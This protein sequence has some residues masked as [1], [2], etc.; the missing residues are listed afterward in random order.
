MNFWTRF[1]IDTLGGY[2]Q[3]KAKGNLDCL[4]G[5]DYDVGV[6]SEIIADGSS[7]STMRHESQRV[8]TLELELRIPYKMGALVCIEPAWEVLNQNDE[9]ESA[10]TNNKESIIK[11]KATV[12][13]PKSGIN[14]RFFVKNAP[15]FFFSTLFE[16]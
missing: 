1:D 8:Q 9:E 6:C 11:Q 3:C 16:K 10:N 7:G 4:M 5:L 15:N 14:Q 13:L 12:D 2:F